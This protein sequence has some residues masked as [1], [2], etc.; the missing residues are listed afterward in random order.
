MRDTIQ[1]QI[2]MAAGCLTAAFLGF[3]AVVLASNH[4]AA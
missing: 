2:I 3:I 4:F 1:T